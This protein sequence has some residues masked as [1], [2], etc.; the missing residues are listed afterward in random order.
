MPKQ[1][2][3]NKIKAFRSYTIPEAAEVSGVSTRTIRSWS[4]KGLRVMRDEHPALIRGDEL[5][6]FIKAQRKRRK[7]S[8]SLDRFYC[9]RCRVPRK[10]AEDL[11]ECQ[12]SGG[13]LTLIAICESCETIMRKPIARSDFPKLGGLFDLSSEDGAP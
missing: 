8:L 11:V 5:I 10:P 12:D 9:L 13:R 4:A 3:I 2:R 6:G 7:K 1:A